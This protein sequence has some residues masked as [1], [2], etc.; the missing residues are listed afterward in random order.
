MNKAV[1]LINVGSP[2]N[3]DTTSVRRYLREF[4][5]D[6]FVID[7]PAAAR[8]MLL[9]FI[10]LPFRPKKSAHLYQKIWT[11]EGSP[12]I[13]NTRK[14]AD[15]LQKQLGSKA[16]VRY[17]MRYGNPSIES[18]LAEISKEN[19]REI[20]IWPQYP[21][22]SNSA[23]ASAIKKVYSAAGNYWNVPPL[24]VIG[25]FFDQS[26]FLDAY[27]ASAREYL[28]KYESSG[29]KLDHILFSFHGVPERH[30]QKSDTTG[31]CLKENCCQQQGKN[32]CYQNHC[33]ATA[34]GIADRLNL[35]PDSW[36]VSFQSRLGKSAWISPYTEMR[37]TELASSGARNIAVISP[38]FV[39]DCL[40][41][42]EELNIRGREEFMKAGGENFVFIPS[43]N[44]SELWVRGASGFLD[45][46]L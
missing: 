24:R 15:A 29:K 9:N 7:I 5:S 46:M 20:L 39:C 13:V 35:K 18:A 43:L 2:D 6:P 26:F 33:H 3:P 27:A 14:F 45:A 4:L 32:Y 11:S 1:I 30:I 42:L 21:Q 23:T 28:D 17:A 40:E 10:I 12:L 8:W 34:A 19:I 44:D 37:L 31:G 25:S 22:Y 16:L 36:S 38:S 41:T